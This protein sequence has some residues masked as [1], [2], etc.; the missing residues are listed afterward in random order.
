[1]QKLYVG[2]MGYDECRPAGDAAHGTVLSAE[3]I[4]DRTNRS[5]GSVVRW[6]P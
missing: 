1:M 4:M 6:T 2:N 3:V 5:K